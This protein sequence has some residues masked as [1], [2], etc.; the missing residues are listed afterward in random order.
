MDRK[1]RWRALDTHSPLD[2]KDEFNKRREEVSPT[3]VGLAHASVDPLVIIVQC[4]LSRGIKAGN[5]RQTP[6]TVSVPTANN[7]AKKRISHAST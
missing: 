6:T 1:A 4:L 2:Y 3:R 7:P 5:I